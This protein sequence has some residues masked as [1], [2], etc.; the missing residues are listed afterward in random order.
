MNLRALI[1]TLLTTTL[2]I[3]GCIHI[4]SAHIH[5]PTPYQPRIDREDMFAAGQDGYYDYK[6]GDHLIVGAEVNRYTHRSQAEIYAHRRASEVCPKGYNVIQTRDTD[7][8]K[9]YGVMELVITCK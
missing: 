3:S 5:A 4:P 6:A 9:L 8:T 2:F 7:A 1:L